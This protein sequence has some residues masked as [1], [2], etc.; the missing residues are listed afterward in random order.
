MAEP[1]V[2]TLSAGLSSILGTD[3][4]PDIAQRLID[5]VCGLAQAAGVTDPAERQRY[6]A[7][8]VRQWVASQISAWET[9]L[10]QQDVP[11]VDPIDLG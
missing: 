10:A 5:A 2:E 3:V 7:D 4:S 9:M 11:P 6:T 1:F 8:A